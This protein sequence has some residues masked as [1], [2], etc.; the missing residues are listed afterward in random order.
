MIVRFYWCFV[1][2]LYAQPVD[3]SAWELAR[4]IVGDE[5][6]ATALAAA[7]VRAQPVGLELLPLSAFDSEIR[8]EWSQRGHMVAIDALAAALGPI[9]ERLGA[10]ARDAFT[11]EGRD[12]GDH[13]PA[14]FASWLGVRLAEVG[15][16]PDGTTA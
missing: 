9:L 8:R 1:G 4:L 3:D 16:L 14:S 5:T 11:S 2:N 15:E 12:W 7:F 10:R 6:R 13:P